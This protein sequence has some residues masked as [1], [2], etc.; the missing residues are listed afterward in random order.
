M[1]FREFAAAMA[2]KESG[3]VVEMLASDTSDVN[4]GNCSPSSNVSKSGTI[5]FDTFINLSD[6]PCNGLF[7]KW[8]IER[9]LSHHPRE[10]NPILHQF[11]K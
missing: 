7:P 3:F 5:A 9:P 10:T 2:S 8:Y 6:T 1:Q 11:I 4:P